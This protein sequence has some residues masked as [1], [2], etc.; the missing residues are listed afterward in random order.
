MGPVQEKDTMARVSAIKKI[1][2]RLPIFDLASTEFEMLPGKA[3]SKR[4]KKDK[5][6][7]KKT[8]AKATLSQTL[9]EI[10]FKMPEL[11]DFRK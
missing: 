3:I 7:T 10:L 9:V 6:K 2:P 5:A 11:L 8:N 1:P 4:P